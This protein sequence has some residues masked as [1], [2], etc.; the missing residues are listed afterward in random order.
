MTKNSIALIG[1]MA[2]GKTT[3]GKALTKYLGNDYKF[4]E[5]DAIIIQKARK[6]IPRIF[7]EDGEERFREYESSACEKVWKLNKVILSCGGGVV[8][9]KTYIDK[10]KQNYH[11]VLLKATIEE[12][13]KRSMKDGKE[14]RPLINKA[15]PK[16]EIIK[17][18]KLR[19][20]YYNNAA[21]IVINTTGKK[22]KDIINEI[23]K[24]TLVK[25]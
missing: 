22:I 12:I 17:I 13:Y 10:I 3:L 16:K 7:E 2:T 15:D 11:I 9:N 23:V 14:T 18:L 19:S 5:T 21:E 4:L 6:S 20:Q 1:F 25:T 8:L 24:K